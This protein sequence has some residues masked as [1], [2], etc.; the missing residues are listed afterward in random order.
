MRDI[1]SL[2]N[3][4]FDALER[5]AQASSE[6]LEQEINKAASIVQLSEAVIKSAEVENQFL[7]ITRGLG[8]GF[9]PL[10]K[11][12]KS[13]LEIVKEQADEHQKTPYKDYLATDAK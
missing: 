13:L 3:H 12:N 2:R 8:S 11:G 7:S 5:V 10:V 4:L 9:I 1:T 6:E